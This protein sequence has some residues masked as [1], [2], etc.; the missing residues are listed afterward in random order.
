MNSFEISEEEKLKQDIH[1][2]KYW[3]RQN[4][5]DSYYSLWENTRN[6]TGIA[7]FFK[8]LAMS[9]EELAAV[10]GKIQAWRDNL[11]ASVAGAFEDKRLM[12]AMRD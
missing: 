2:G 6:R 4:A 7:A 12:R 9:D 3:R 11:S 1:R 10:V 8:M 5:V